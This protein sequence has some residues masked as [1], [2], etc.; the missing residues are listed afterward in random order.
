MII[1]L[2]QEIKAQTKNEYVHKEWVLHHFATPKFFIR[3]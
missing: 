1:R 2:S 3:F